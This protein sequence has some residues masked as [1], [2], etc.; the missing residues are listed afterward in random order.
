[1]KKKKLLVLM[2]S[3]SLGF[4][5]M[6]E[7]DNVVKTVNEEQTVEVADENVADSV[8]PKHWTL[9]SSLILTAEQTQIDNWA[10]GGYSN[11]AFGGLFKGFYNYLNKKHKVDNT[12]EL[13]YGR[14]R[15]DLSGEGIFDK[16]NTWVKSDDKIEL[17]S[18]YGYQAVKNWNYSGLLNLKTQFDN[19]YKVS[20]GDTIPV[21]AGLSPIVLTTSVGMEYKTANFSAMFS[22]LTGKTTFVGDRRLR[23]KTAHF[24]YTDDPDHAWKFS[25]GSYIKLFYQKDIFTN[26]NLLAKLDFFWDYE[27]PLIDTDINGE[28]FLTMK[29]SKY[30][31]A[32]VSIQA[33]IDKDFSTALQFKERFGIS[34][35]LNF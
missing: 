15:Q 35:P 27:K 17:N 8:K 24:G 30:L 5:V 12:V 22:F 14:T 31:S 4:G 7:E 26:V 34:I 23:G 6:A 20:S 33:A 19:G 2:L 10:A 1:M 18:I 16:T 21:S 11:I 28:L 13:A 29:I 9:K 32:F 3:V 25:L